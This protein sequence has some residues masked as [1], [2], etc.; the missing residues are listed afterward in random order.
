M[1]SVQP[2]ERFLAGEQTADSA[3]LM[4]SCGTGAL[5]VTLHQSY[6][7]TSVFCTSS[8]SVFAILEERADAR[9][10]PGARGRVFC[11]SF[12]RSGPSAFNTTRLL[13]YSLPLKVHA[14]F[15]RTG[16]S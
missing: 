3:A 16:D 1:G 5:R 14:V 13:S 9:L 7:Y 10:H 6:L 11:Q 8:H 2:Q 12:P 4:R 15:T